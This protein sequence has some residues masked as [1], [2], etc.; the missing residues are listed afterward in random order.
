MRTFRIIF[1][2][3][4]LGVS[5]CAYLPMPSFLA[6]AGDVFM[7]VVIANS[8]SPIVIAA[9]NKRLDKNNFSRAAIDR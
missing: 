7:H 5:V 4:K 3:H 1:L 2:T 8:L 9:T 6:C